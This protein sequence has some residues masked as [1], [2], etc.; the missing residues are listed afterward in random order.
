MRS[1]ETFVCP[2]VINTIKELCG[3][4]DKTYMYDVINYSDICQLISA[5][6]VI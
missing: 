1:T 2:S 4:R 6:S 5:I 3:L